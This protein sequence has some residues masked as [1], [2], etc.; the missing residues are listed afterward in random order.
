MTARP[1]MW[2]ELPPDGAI[3]TTSEYLQT[4]ES[5][6]VQELLYGT[7]QVADSPHFRHQ[8]LLLEI[9]NLLCAYVKHHRLG[10]I[11]IAPQDVILDAA[12]A[13][14]LQPD[15]MF[16]SNA[17]HDIISDHIWGAPALVIEVM[18]PKPRIGRLEDRLGHFDR[19][20][21]KECW[22]VHQLAQEIEVLTFGAGG[23]RRTF[24]GFARLE[25]TIFPELNLAPG[26]FSNW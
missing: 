6:R 26:V 13:L 19:Y 5:V 17:R 25:S 23:R 22:L 14:I 15:L 16:I 2:G 1:S 18:S 3:L 24:K 7:L 20:G 21:V 12:R 8:H 4:A 9:A 11:C 10:T